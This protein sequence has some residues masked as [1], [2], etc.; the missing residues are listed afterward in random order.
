MPK[1]AFVRTQVLKPA[2]SPPLRSA[3]DT[4][5][6]DGSITSVLSSTAEAGAFAIPELFRSVMP[7]QAPSV[8]AKA[9]AVIEAAKQSE[10]EVEKLVP[11]PAQL[12]SQLHITLFRYSP[13]IVKS[14]TAR[15]SKWWH[16]ERVYRV[17]EG[18]LP[19]RKLDGLAIDG[20]LTD[21]RPFPRCLIK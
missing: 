7:S 4:I 21:S 18:S 12:E 10:K 16:A 1:A 15:V 2:R 14:L 8:V 13:A 5:A 3:L 6:A 9:E 17:V 11:S 19:N 20:M